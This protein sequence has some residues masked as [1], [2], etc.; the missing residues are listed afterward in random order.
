MEFE[1][2]LLNVVKYERKEDKSKRVMI[3]Y[4][5]LDPKALQTDSDKFKGYSVL[6]FYFDGHEVFD[7]IPSNYCGKACKFYTKKEVSVYDPTKEF[8]R[9][10][11]INDIDLV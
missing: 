5:L 9:L 10:I 8:N 6:T 3:S 11:K 7:K 4:R 1:V 2:E